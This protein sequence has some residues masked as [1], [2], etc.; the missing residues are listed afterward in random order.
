MTDFDEQVAKLRDYQRVGVQFLTSETGALLADEMGTGKTVQT[1]CA[2]ET[3]RLSG[4]VSRALVV[5]PASLKLNWYRELKEW[6]VGCSVRIVTGDSA[7]REA[8]YALRFNVLIASYEQI[9]T[10]FLWHP[11]NTKFD[12]SLIHI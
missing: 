12:L 4:E 10:D 6:A 11:I 7:L 1:A 3:M 2:L 8:W 9:R 5:V